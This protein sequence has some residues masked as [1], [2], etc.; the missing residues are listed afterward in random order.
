MSVN[1]SDPQEFHSQ[2]VD[3]ASR[4]HEKGGGEEDHLSSIQSHAEGAQGFQSE[5]RD[6]LAIQPRRVGSTGRA[7]KTSSVGRVSGKRSGS[8]VPVLIL[9]GMILVLALYIGFFDDDEEPAGEGALTSQSATSSRSEPIPEPT[10]RSTGP[11]N[12]FNVA[13]AGYDLL[14]AGKLQPSIEGT[15]LEALN[16]EF[17]ASNVAPATFS[18]SSFKLLGGDVIEE[19]GQ[20]LPAL[21]YQQGEYVLYVTEVPFAHLKEENGFYVAGDIL[22]QLESGDV[23]WSPA[24]SNGTIALWVEGDKAMIAL[25]NRSKPDLANIIGK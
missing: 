11:I 13:I 1:Y 25:A 23:V 18:G 14:V 9:L 20:K 4:T 22:S 2:L 3:L 17:G 10:R 16:Q 8:G 5:L 15:N 12:F 7:P 21:L 6:R 19:R 24:P